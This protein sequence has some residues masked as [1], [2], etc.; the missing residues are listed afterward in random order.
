MAVL[1]LAIGC[2]RAES[3]SSQAPSDQTEAP[4]PAPSEPEPAQPAVEN[5]SPEQLI[6]LPLDHPVVRSFIGDAKL[7]EKQYPDV[8]YESSL[9]RG[10]DLV[11]QGGVITTVSLKAGHPDMGIPP[12]T[13]PLPSGIQWDDPPDRARQL[14]GTPDDQGPGYDR[15]NHE[16]W[17]LLLQYANGGGVRMVIVE[18]VDPQRP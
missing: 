17:S 16:A 4:S 14:L 13:G 2:D 12:Y 7:E 5:A 3:P 6:G 15:W 1:V 18:R 10:F 11:L 8:V 9:E